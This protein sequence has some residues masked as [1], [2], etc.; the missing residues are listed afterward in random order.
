MR[1]EQQKKEW[2][3]TILTTRLKFIFSPH[4]IFLIITHPQWRYT[5]TLSA[6]KHSSRTWHF[7]YIYWKWND[8]EKRSRF[9]IIKYN[10]THNNLKVISGK[11]SLKKWWKRKLVSWVKRISVYSLSI[12]S[13]ETIHNPMRGIHISFPWSKELV[14]SECIWIGKVFFF[15]E[16]PEIFCG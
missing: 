8:R 14:E 6:S 9:R 15:A 13:T 10:L 2:K 5:R 7:R 16:R 1:N 12:Y 3:M 4:T 11:S